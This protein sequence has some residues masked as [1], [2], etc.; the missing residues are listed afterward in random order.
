MAVSGAVTGPAA[1]MG[2]VES[3]ISMNEFAEHRHYC[4]E[5]AAGTRQESQR[6][7]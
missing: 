7:G 4:Q 6:F 5:S 3:G 2:A 1:G